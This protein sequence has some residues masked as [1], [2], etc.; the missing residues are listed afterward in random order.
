MKK[1]VN[2][3]LRV[4][5]EMVEGLLLADRRL[6]RIDGENVVL[7]R[8]HRAL[9]ASGR[10]ARNSVGDSPTSFLNTRLKCVSDWNPTS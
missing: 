8:D 5:E 7:R 1:L 10:V 3:P 4:V 9:A 6:T 2:D